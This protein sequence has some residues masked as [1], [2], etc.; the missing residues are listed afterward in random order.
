MWSKASTKERKDLVITEVSKK[1]ECYK[2]KAVCLK[3]QG[4]WT[5]SEAINRN[6]TC[7]D[8][9]KMPQARP[10]FL[11]R[12]TYDILPSPQNLH[13][14]YGLEK[15]CHPCSFQ[16]SSIQHILSGC[17]AA[18]IQ[19]HYIWRHDQVLR[20]LAEVLE[21]RRLEANRAHS[22]LSQQRT[23]FV[24][25]GGEGQSSSLKEWS[26][27]S[28]GEEW[29]MAADLAHQLRFWV[30]ITFLRP[31]IILWSTPV[32]TVIMVK[33]TVPLE[34]EGLEVAFERKK[35]SSSA[36]S[37]LAPFSPLALLSNSDVPEASSSP[38]LAKDVVPLASP[39]ASKAI[40]PPWLCLGHPCGS[41]GLS[42]PS[43][44]ALVDI[45]HRLPAIIIYMDNVTTLLQTAKVHVQ[46]Y[47][48]AGGAASMSLDEDKAR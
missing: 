47:Q 6:I 40:T 7:A 43:S 32:K 5:I 27:L 39:Q 19:G 48:K 4:R 45:G 26:L 38:A 46:T 36:S 14:W 25:Q 15:N 35:E 29:S 42:R 10:S 8:M 20:K 9:W 2:V 21:M 1:E 13:F 23:H 44:S 28:P 18:L 16:N 3:Q 31:D 41:T 37:T 17:K 12:A 22:T 34:E 11:I 33:L 24:R 30:E